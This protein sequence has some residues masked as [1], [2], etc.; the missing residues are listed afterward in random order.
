MICALHSSY[1]AHKQ[2]QGRN[3][4]SANVSIMTTEVKNLF[5]A[6]V[7]LRDRGINSSN[8]H[9]SGKTWR[10]DRR[11]RGGKRD[12]SF[13]KERE[14]GETRKQIQ[15][16]LGR[17]TTLSFSFDPMLPVGIYSNESTNGKKME[18]CDLVLMMKTV[19]H[20]F[21]DCRHVKVFSWTMKSC[22][23][24]GNRLGKLDIKYLDQSHTIKTPPD[25]ADFVFPA[26]LTC[27]KCRS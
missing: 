11:V 15:F 10:H 4:P 13:Y 21:M 12:T 20:L 7:S 17:S 27:F 23:K 26:Q 1:T 3:R 25:S 9:K 5:H 19:R 18:S 14:E 22:L 8:S 6:L 16:L 2:G 24:L